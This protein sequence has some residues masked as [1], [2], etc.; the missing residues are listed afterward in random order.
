MKRTS[1][2]RK[3]G[4]DEAPKLKASDFARAK[5]RV[6]GKQVERAEWQAAV[7]ERIGK[8]RIT[9]MID[10]DVLAAYKARAG[11]RGYQTLINQA[12]RQAMMGEQIEATLRRV[13][14]EELHAR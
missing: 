6:A 11:A 14:R 9:I 3:S 12:L 7:R 10:A 1:T 8:E 13:I 4:A 2:T 5:F